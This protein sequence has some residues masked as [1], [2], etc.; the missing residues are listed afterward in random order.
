MK[1]KDQL[2]AQVCIELKSIIISKYNHGSYYKRM[3]ELCHVISCTLSK[4][5]RTYNTVFY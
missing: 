5:T 4:I 3:H 2:L 1:Q